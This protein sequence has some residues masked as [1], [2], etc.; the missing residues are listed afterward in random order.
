MID[1]GILK[2]ILQMENTYIRINKE[3]FM[4]EN[5]RITKDMGM[6]KWNTKTD[7]FIKDNGRIMK[8]KAKANTFLKI[9]KMA[10]MLEFS[11]VNLR[12]VCLMAKE[13]M[14]LGITGWWKDNG[15]IGSGM[16]KGR[17]EWEILLLK[18]YGSRTN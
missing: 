2:N 17:Q 16:G 6:E 12:M 18:G 15:K 5:G 9:K 8:N 4:M 7:K 14:I 11:K 13:H 3:T 10:V 1:G